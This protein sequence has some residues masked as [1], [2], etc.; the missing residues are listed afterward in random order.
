METRQ[1]RR[2]R[3]LALNAIRPVRLASASYAFHYVACT[4]TK[5]KWPI[6]CRMC[7]H[8][9]VCVYVCVCDTFRSGIRYRIHRAACGCLQCTKR[10]TEIV[11]W[12]QLKE[13]CIRNDVVNASS[14]LKRM[15]PGH[16]RVKGTGR[17]A[18]EL[19]SGQPSASQRGMYRQ[20]GSLFVCLPLSDFQV[21]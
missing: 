15:G 4:W 2:K 10:A 13:L 20:Q 21:S 11:E 9:C 17:L 5:L 19:V 18:R 7:M 6:A 1:I 3:R 14:C 12:G 16:A 8:V